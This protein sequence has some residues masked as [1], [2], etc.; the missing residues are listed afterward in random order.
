[1]LCMLGSRKIFPGGG[2]GVG[3]IFNFVTEVLVHIIGNFTNFT[4]HAITSI[5]NYT[6]NIMNTIII[7]FARMLLLKIIIK[8]II[9]LK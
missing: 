4:A 2:G 5:N 9:I 1:M 6:Q 3:G 7:I 8:L